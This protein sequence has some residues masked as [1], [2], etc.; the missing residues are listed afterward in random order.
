MEQDGPR[1]N[2]YHS[3]VMDMVH[4]VY[5]PAAPPSFV[6][7]GIFHNERLIGKREEG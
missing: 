5:T 2:S 7:V 4:G 1:V 6:G 3:W